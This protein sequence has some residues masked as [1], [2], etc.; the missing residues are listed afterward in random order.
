MKLLDIDTVS[1]QNIDHALK[2]LVRLGMTCGT[3]ITGGKWTV[4]IKE[5][6]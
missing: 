5:K 3:L 6:K 1:A 2:H 4:P